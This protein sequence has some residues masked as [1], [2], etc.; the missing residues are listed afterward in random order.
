[1]INPLTKP[2]GEA[3]HFRITSVLFDPELRAYVDLT[4]AAGNVKYSGICINANA[5][6]TS[7]VNTQVV[8][9]IQS[10]LAAR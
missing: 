2:M 3:T 9:F 6:V 5:E 1:M 10:D 4:D 7:F 8:G